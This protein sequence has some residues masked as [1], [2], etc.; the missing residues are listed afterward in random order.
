MKR[1]H[2]LQWEKRGRL[3]AFFRRVY[4]ERQILVRT[5]GRI[6][7]VPLTRTKQVALTSLVAALALW[8]IYT[9]VGHFAQERI[10]ATK[11]AAVT[12]ARLAY[13]GLLNEVSEYQKRFTAL[14]AELEENH[15]LM[16]K[17]VEQNANLQQNLKTVKG[18]LKTSEAARRSVVAAREEL[19]QRLSKIEGEMRALAG[20]NFSLKGSLASMEDNIE[21]LKSQRDRAVSQKAKLNNRV[22]DLENTLVALRESEKDLLQRLTDHT[23]ARIEDLEKVLA[24]TGVNVDRLLASADRGE[25][26][27]GPFIAFKAEDAGPGGEL[28]AA[29]NTLDEH[30]DRWAGLQ[31]LM[32]RLPLSAPLDYFYITSGYG[33]RRDPVNKRWAMHYGLDLGSSYRASVYATAPGKVTYAG[34]KGNYGKLVEIDHGS[35]VKTRY[36]HLYKVLVKKGDMVGHRTK[37]GL[38]G[39]TGRS[40][41]AHLHYEVRVNRK[42]TNPLKFIKAGKHVFK[43]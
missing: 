11:E 43:G 34:W 29:L 24:R 21:D 35:G 40:T 23:T 15:S 9:T 17:L 18:D 1:R 10:L 5:G 41:G 33:K 14:T 13:S 36:G 26:Q 31:K 4:P 42:T 19:K 20:R 37:I 39:N 2:P 38:V 7:Y 27:G 12:K 25:R 30:I 3:R 16:L 8:T 32:T 28:K 6:R 22:A